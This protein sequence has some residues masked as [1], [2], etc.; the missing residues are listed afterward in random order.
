MCPFHQSCEKNNY[1]VIR[2]KPF[3]SYF[4]LVSWP[5]VFV[6]ARAQIRILHSEWGASY[7]FVDHQISLQA[8]SLLSLA[9]SL[10]T[11]TDTGFCCLGVSVTRWFLHTDFYTQ[12]L[13]T[14][15]SK[16]MI[17]LMVVSCSTRLSSV[18]FSRQRT[19]K[20]SIAICYPYGSQRTSR[21]SLLSLL[22]QWSPQYLGNSRRQY[23]SLWWRSG[24]DPRFHP[25]LPGRRR[26]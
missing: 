12:V 26:C 3:L 11:A 23:A 6:M 19:E 13:L 10:L 1:W 17:T 8:Q 16:L 18:Y 22:R 9:L 5:L 14:T 24:L 2:C 7:K 20:Y 4:L 15:R 21:S 25:H